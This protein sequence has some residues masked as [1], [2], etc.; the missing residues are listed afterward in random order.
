MF[1]RGVKQLKQSYLFSLSLK[2][3]NLLT[4]A[5]LNTFLFL[6]L[7][8]VQLFQKESYLDIISFSVKG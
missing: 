4:T 7:I 2:R 8:Y 3:Q 1:E 5:C 6:F